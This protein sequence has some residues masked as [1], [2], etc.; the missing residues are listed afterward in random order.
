MTCSRVQWRKPLHHSSRRLALRMVILGLCVVARPWKL[1]SECRNRGQTICTRF[2]SP[3]DALG[4]PHHPLESPAVAGGAVAVPDGDTAQQDALNCASVKVC[5][6]FRGQDKFLQPPEFA[7]SSHCVCVD[8]FR[9]SVNLS[10]FST[11]VPSMWIGVCSL[12]CVLKSTISAFVLLTLS[13]RLFSW[14]H[15]L[16]AL[17]SSL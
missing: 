9:S 4:R 12:C 6:G 1:N 7:P 17:T 14:H 5:E 10:T 15:S 13:E 3:G 16:R 8:Q 11:A 2:K